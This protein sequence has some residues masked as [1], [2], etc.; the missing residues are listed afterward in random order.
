MS[1]YQV[2]V[3][4]AGTAGVMAAVQ[5]ARAGARTLLVERSSML[6]GTITQAS[7]AFPG[8]F[9]AWGSQV[10]AGIGWELVS[11]CVAQGGGTM[12]DFAAPAHR[13]WEHQVR[14]NGPLYGALCDEAVVASGADL[15]LHTSVAQIGRA[16]ERWSFRLCT[17]AGLEGCTAD[18]IVDCTG[19][20]CVARMAGCAV[21]Q[22]SADELQPGSLRYRLGGFDPADLDWPA[23]QQAAQ[24]AVNSGELRATDL[25]WDAQK[26]DVRSFLCAPDAQPN[27]IG[28]LSA[29]DARG[30]T[31]MELAGRASMLRVL[32]F[33]QRQKG[34]QRVTIAHCPAATGVR[35]T[36]TIQGRQTVTAAD[37]TSGRL[38]DEAVCY[39]FY[40]IDLH[41]S[42]DGAGLR[43]EP[44]SPGVVATVPRGA[45]L[46]RGIA[47]LVV[48]GRC[49][50]SDRLANS[51]LRV[52]AT[53][54]A[55]GQAAGALAVLAAM[56]HQNV[57]R[58]PMAGLG[59]VLREH[60]AIVPGPP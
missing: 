2:A 57:D 49:I 21:R 17:M 23:L 20:A 28:G 34:T 27:H 5:S 24:Q 29:G 18:V 54:M 15:L 16:G 44:L 51:A 32:R 33:L 38:W 52:Q 36:V 6:G 56:T 41:G 25:G 59:K 42:R 14:I 60:G 58:V 37:Y 39:S 30:R 48:A 9:H 1:D 26:V 31:A 11:R 4:G 10:I 7:V 22:A 55:T 45:L 8:L 19:D 47:N 53:C 13:H 40:P 12:P 35:E 46:P 3:I 43:C 50:A